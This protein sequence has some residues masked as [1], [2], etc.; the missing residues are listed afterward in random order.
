[1]VSIDEIVI[2]DYLSPRLIAADRE[3]PLI[4]EF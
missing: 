1:M 2:I 4:R 3:Q